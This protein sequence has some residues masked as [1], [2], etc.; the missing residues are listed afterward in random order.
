M[1][2]AILVILEM[3]RFQTAKQLLLQGILAAA[4]VGCGSG[5][6]PG[7]GNRDLVGSDRDEHGC[8]NSAGYQ[9][10]ASTGQCERPWELAKSKG[11]ANT[12]AEY[13][14]FCQP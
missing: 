12:E 7:A 6:D 8:I 4:L 13:A 2:K 5:D 1:N 14:A 10:C 11:F 9:W 3:R